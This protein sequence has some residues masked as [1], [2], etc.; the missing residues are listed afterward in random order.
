MGN[1]FSSDRRS[2]SRGEDR[3]IGGI[4]IIPNPTPI[5]PS[6][7]PSQPHN[8]N[9]PGNLK[10]YQLSIESMLITSVTLEQ[11][12]TFAQMDQHCQ[13]LQNKIL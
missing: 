13:F 5:I 1:C 4:P 9:L 10:I 2:D 11:A 12:L 7:T 6:S 8:E 3:V